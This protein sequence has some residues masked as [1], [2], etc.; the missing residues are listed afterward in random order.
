MTRFLVLRHGETQWNLESRVQGHRDSPLTAAGL[1]QADAL[2]RRLATQRFD[3]LVSS[4]LG[5][6]LDTARRIAAATGHAVR[7]DAR[8]RERSFGAAEG[9]T[10]GE[11]DHQFPEVFSQVL[12]TDADYVV[13]GGE[14]RRQLFERVKGG[15]ESLARDHEASSIAVVCHGG[16]LASLYRLIHGIPVSTPHRIPMANAAYNAVSLHDG[17]WS[18]ETWG[19]TAHL[20]VTV[21]SSGAERGSVRIRMS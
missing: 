4:D 1:A 16:V 18:V 9:L 2:A 3:V 17:A 11:L 21:G 7:P 13:P 20:D 10:Y 14:S 15:F 8:F 19:D 5:R 6:A 12:E